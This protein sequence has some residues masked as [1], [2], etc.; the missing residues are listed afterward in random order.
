MK[1]TTKRK[2]TLELEPTDPKLVL[3]TILKTVFFIIYLYGLVTITPP[4]LDGLFSVDLFTWL[5]PVVNA[6]LM[7][8]VYGPLF[9]RILD[10]LDNLGGER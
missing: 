1:K 9:A 7:L 2:I 10:I 5:K 3:K 4:L 8:I 6:V